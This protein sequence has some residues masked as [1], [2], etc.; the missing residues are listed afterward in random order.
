MAKLTIEAP[1]GNVGD[2]VWVLN[3]RRRPEQWETGEISDVYYRPER[4]YERANGNG[5]Y[6]IAAKWTYEI[7][8]ERASWQDGYGRRHGGPYRIQVGQ[9][10][11]R[12]L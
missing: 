4:S 8:I 5:K 2:R 7:W 10:K 11:V 12:P 1:I 9:E 3:Y 6:T